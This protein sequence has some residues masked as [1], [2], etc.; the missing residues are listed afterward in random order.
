MRAEGPLDA[1]R[2]ERLV[3]LLVGEGI[4][5]ATV[6]SHLPSPFAASRTAAS[7]VQQRLWFVNQLRRP[8]SALITCPSRCGSSARSTSRP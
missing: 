8:D 6:R 1:A 3:H 4:D 5:A 2:V 7:A